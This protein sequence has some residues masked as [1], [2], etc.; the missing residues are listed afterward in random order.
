MLPAWWGRGKAWDEAEVSGRL[1]WLRRAGRGSLRQPCWEGSL[2]QGGLVG[3]PW[4]SAQAE[5]VAPAKPACLSPAP[6]ASSGHLKIIKRRLKFFFSICL[7][8]PDGKQ[9]DL[10]RDCN[11]SHG[12]ER[13]LAACARGAS[14]IAKR[15]LRNG[16][17]DVQ[18]CALEACL[19]QFYLPGSLQGS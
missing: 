14:G 7:D 6:V 1:C 8:F 13:A 18:P 17:R 10:F 5:V 11:I 2:R 4:L 15:P 12:V 19:E 3:S 9:G 16:R